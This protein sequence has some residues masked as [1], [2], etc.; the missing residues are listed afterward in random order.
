MKREPRSFV[1]DAR[2]SA[3]TIFRFVQGKTETD[4]SADRMLSSAVERQFGIIGE[5][6]RTRAEITES[7]G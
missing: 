2:E 7:P 4:Y 1:W 3:D 6:L 5:A